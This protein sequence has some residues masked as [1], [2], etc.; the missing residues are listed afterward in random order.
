VS[1]G[2][3]CEQVGIVEHEVGHAL[4]LWHEQ[5]RPDADAYIKLQPDNIIQLMISNFLQRCAVHNV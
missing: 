5:S 1:I 3:G 4:G 2:D